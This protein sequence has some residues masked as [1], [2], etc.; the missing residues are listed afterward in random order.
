MNIHSFS[1][2][3]SLQFFSTI[4]SNKKSIH[5]WRI[6]RRA[7]KHHHR[8]WIDVMVTVFIRFVFS[9][10]GIFYGCAEKKKRL[11]NKYLNVQSERDISD[12]V[13]KK[14]NDIKM[15]LKIRY[16]FRKRFFKFKVV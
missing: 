12:A 16:A 8:T 13:S 5:L 7:C 1:F 10:K 15:K 6:K 14:L 4:I 3:N 11:T 9:L 2:F